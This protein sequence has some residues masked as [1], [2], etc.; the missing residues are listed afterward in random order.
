[1]TGMVVLQSTLKNE[2]S[3]KSRHD[4]EIVAMECVWLEIR[5][6]SK[7][8]LVGTFYRTPNSDSTILTQIENSIDLARDTEI[9]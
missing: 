4:L 3:C 2:I 7:R 6:H 1:M 9:S 5:L 8:L